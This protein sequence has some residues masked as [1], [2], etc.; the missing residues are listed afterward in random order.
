VSY[1]GVLHL[2]EAVAQAIA[3]GQATEYGETYFYVSP[4]FET[5]DARYAWLNGAFLVSQGR[6]GPGRVEYRVF[7]V[8]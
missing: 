6:V 8:Q 7:E 3:G 1:V 5:G 4:R 2:T